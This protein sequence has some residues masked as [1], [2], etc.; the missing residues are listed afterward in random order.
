MTM[1]KKKL[2]TD[3]PEN[4]YEGIGIEYIRQYAELPFGDDVIRPGDKIRFHRRR[5]VFKFRYMYHNVQ[6]DVQWIDC[7]DEASGQFRSFYL[8]ELKTV[9]RPK[10][11]RRRVRK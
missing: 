8:D 4:P 9:I 7:I 6:K 5:G 11:S 10:K 1:A 2:R 3:I